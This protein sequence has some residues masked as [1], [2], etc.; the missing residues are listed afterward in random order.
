[1]ILTG[2]LNVNPDTC[3]ISLLRNRYVNCR[4]YNSQWR[5][6]RDS[7]GRQLSVP[8]QLLRDYLN[9]SPD[10]QYRNVVE[11]RRRGIKDVKKTEVNILLVLGQM[12]NILSVI[13]FYVST[14]NLNLNHTESKK[15]ISFC[16]NEF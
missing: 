5:P 2:D 4:N 1:M 13:N 7:E 3:L 8:D 14:Y 9:I 15:A 12:L 16:W 6:V 11:G 10:C